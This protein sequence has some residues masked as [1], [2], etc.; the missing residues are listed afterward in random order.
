MTVDHPRLDA[1]D[2]SLEVRQA[3]VA[4]A[5]SPVVVGVTG[6]T[7]TVDLTDGTRVLHTLSEGEYGVSVGEEGLKL[8]QLGRAPDGQRE[9]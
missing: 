9:L 7:A 8:H 4:F 3:S 5:S 1:I 6:G 2:M